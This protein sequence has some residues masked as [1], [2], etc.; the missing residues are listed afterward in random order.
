MYKIQNFYKSKICIKST[1]DTLDNY[2]RLDDNYNRFDNINKC[3]YCCCISKWWILWWIFMILR[4][5]FRLDSYGISLIIRGNVAVLSSKLIPDNVIMD[6][7]KCIYNNKIIFTMRYQSL[8]VQ[9]NPYNYE[10][11]NKN[12]LQNSLLWYIITV[13]TCIYII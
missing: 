7:K 5:R 8:H 10:K 6:H 1:M 11:I 9:N 12:S 13:A 4:S 2:D 3:S